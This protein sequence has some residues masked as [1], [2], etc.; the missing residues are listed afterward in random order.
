MRQSARVGRL[1]MLAVGMSIGA[2]LA[3]PRRSPRPTRLP[4]RFRGSIKW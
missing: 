2:A 3:P 1:G 4:I